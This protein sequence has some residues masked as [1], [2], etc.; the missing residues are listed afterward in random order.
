MVPEKFKV[1]SKTNEITALPEG[2]RMLH[3]TGAVVAIDAM[4]CQVNMARQIQ[5]QGA[6]Y[7]RSVKKISPACTTI[8]PTCLCGSGVHI[9]SISLSCWATMNRSM[10]ARG[11]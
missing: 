7:V 10:V 5:V 4:G 1:D 3:L 6:D 11:G 9:S 2:L 8:V